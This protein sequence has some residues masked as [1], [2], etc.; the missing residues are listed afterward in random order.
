MLLHELILACAGL[1]KH[2]VNGGLKA[3]LEAR[4]V[5]DRAADP[6]GFDEHLRLAAYFADRPELTQQLINSTQQAAAPPAPPPHPH[7]QPA[8]QP[9]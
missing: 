9:K 5:A 8:Q 7:P 1:L 6:A 4:L 3:F 2:N